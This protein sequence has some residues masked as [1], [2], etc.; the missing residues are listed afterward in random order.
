MRVALNVYIITLALVF[1]GAGAALTNHIRDT[2]T[3]PSVNRST[4][5]NK[6]KHVVRPDGDQW[7]CFGAGRYDAMAKG[8][9]CPGWEDF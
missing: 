2:Q 3:A 4:K 1:F 7:T 8:E 9:V 5:V 6:L